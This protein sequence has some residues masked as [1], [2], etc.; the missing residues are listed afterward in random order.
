MKSTDSELLTA[1]QAG[2]SAALGEILERHEK[3]VFR[4]G[5][6]ICGSED[7]AREVLQETLLAAFRKL[8]DFR[9]EATLS[10]WLYQ[11]ARSFCLKRR[12][13]GAF[14]PDSLLSIDTPEAAAVPTEAEPAD[15][16]AYAREVGKILQAAILTLPEAHQRAIVLRDVEGLPAEQVARVLGIGVGALKSRL[17]RARLELR[18]RLSGVLGETDAGLQAPCSAL[19]P[20]RP[21]PVFADTDI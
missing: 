7:D 21:A 5:M 3:Q 8:N 14:E 18:Q 15:E 13:R 19:V 6:R 2:N 4:F 11:I 12:R 16:S 10:T 17:H 20:E 1:A 9:G